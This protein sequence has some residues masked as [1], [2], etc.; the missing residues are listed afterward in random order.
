MSPSADLHRHG[1]DSASYF[2]NQ[3]DF[4]QRKE[5]ASADLS[6]M[7]QR[8]LDLNSKFSLMMGDC[9]AVL[10]ANKWIQTRRAIGQSDSVLPLSQSAGVLIRQF[11]LEL[12]SL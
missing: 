10:E 6:A 12:L 8:I 7:E 5:E 3:L 4:N 9:R 1:T 11:R 2:S